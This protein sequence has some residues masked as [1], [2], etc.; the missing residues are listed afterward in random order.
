MLMKIFSQNTDQE[1]YF[2]IEHLQTNL[3]QKAVKA[4]GI[5][6]FTRI[7]VFA[8]QL[9]GTMILA[10]LLI[11]GDF[12]L[13]AMVTVIAGILIEFGILRL[14]DATVQ[15]KDLN[16]QQVSTL[17]WIN[18]GLCFLLAIFFALSSPILVWFYNEPRLKSII[19]AIASGFIFSGLCIQPMALL[20]RNMEFSKIAASQ[21][22]SIFITDIV[23]IIM[24]WQGCGYWSLV[25]R[26][27]GYP[28]TSAAG[29]WILCKW[30]PGQPSRIADVW[31][32]LKFGLNSL[33]NYTMDYFTRSLD[34]LLVGWRYGNQ[35]LGYYDR[36]YYLYGVPVNQLS[37]PLT[38]VAVATLSRLSDDPEKYKSYYLKAMSILAFIGMALSA[39]LTLNGKDIILILLGEQWERAGQIITL[40]GPG[41]GIM[42]IYGTNG[43]LHL[44]LGRTDRW[45][46][47]GIISF[48]TTALLFL[49]GLP[50]GP[51]GIAVA[52]V[53][54]YYFLIIPCL[55]YAGHPVKLNLHSIVSIIWKYFLSALFAGLICWSLL[56]SYKPV[57]NIFYSCNVISR[58]FISSSLCTCIY[59]LLIIALYRSTKPISEFISLFGE[60]IPAL[61]KKS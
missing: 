3:K 20:Q 28:M 4:S 58:I 32:M 57:S 43:W 6:V 56:Y 2:N 10:R 52:Y 27:V 59:L 54:T 11:P 22:V 45:F 35:S 18:V 46:R 7:A 41:V 5:T 34:K 29:L 38:S 60:M 51:E 36:A 31:P 30:R 13:V 47:W 61:K 55:L 25:V 8:S 23:V 12:G 40:F 9:I 48:I 16:H 42:V 21:V 33:G 50:F 14:G 37:Y 17:F 49:I 44:S 53:S 39:I 1:K 19:I 26:R 15:K 24:A